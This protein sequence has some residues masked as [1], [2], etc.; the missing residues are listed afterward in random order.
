[1]I[2]VVVPIKRVDLFSKA[3]GKISRDGIREFLAEL[4]REA[5]IFIHKIPN[6]GNKPF[7]GY[8][9]TP[10]PETNVDI[11][12]MTTAATKPTS[13]TTQDEAP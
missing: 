6:A 12:L 1:M 3:S 9:K 4:L 13:K 10:P 8:A 5:R 2:P 7:T 11:N